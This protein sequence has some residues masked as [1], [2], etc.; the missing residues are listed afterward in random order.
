VRHIERIEAEATTPLP[1]RADGPAQ[2]FDELCARLEDS[3]ARL[4][5]PLPQTATRGAGPRGVAEPLCRARQQ[6]RDGEEMLDAIAERARYTAE[7]AAEWERR[8][9]LAVEAG[10]DALAREALAHRA[11]MANLHRPLQREV[12]AGRA[13]LAEMR[14]ALDRIAPAGDDAAKR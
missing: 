5:A 7:A 12:T 4:R 8:A 2:R 1:A 14:A 10:S 11:E 13:V 6:L 3:I 9:M